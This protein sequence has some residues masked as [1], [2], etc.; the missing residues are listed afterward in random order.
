MEEG[1][2]CYECGRLINES[3]PTVF[4]DGKT[5][6]KSCA[7]TLQCYDCRRVIGYQVKGSSSGNRIIVC[8][9]CAGHKNVSV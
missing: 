5:F 3:Q 2:Y 9:E 7:D 4:A 6:H 8:V 1:I